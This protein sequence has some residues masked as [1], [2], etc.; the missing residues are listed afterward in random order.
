MADGFFPM[1]NAEFAALLSETADLMEIA[2][3]DPFRIRSYRNAAAAIETCP[4]RIA[5][6]LANAER[7][8][9]EIRGIGKGIAAILKEIAERGSFERR[10]LLLEK[11]RSEERRV[12]KECRSR[13]S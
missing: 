5:D 4:D 9:T 12:G 8:V 2:G 7:S 11:Y 13:W 10:D 6:I 3:E 1:E